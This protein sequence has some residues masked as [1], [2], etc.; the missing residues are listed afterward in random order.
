MEGEFQILIYNYN[1]RNY[2]MSDLVENFIW[3]RLKHHKN[4]GASTAQYGGRGITPNSFRKSCQY[5]KSFQSRRYPIFF[6]PSNTFS[7]P[8]EKG[9]HL[10]CLFRLHIVC[11]IPPLWPCFSILILWKDRID[12]RSRWGWWEGGGDRRNRREE[13]KD[14]QKRQRQEI[15]DIS[16]SWQLVVRITFC[17]SCNYVLIFGFSR[18]FLGARVFCSHTTGWF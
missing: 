10:T 8:F 15:Y 1:S 2:N 3:M 6:L 7:L 17:N 9:P 14:R 16:F 12:R 18:K 11:I 5:K 13:R 4:H